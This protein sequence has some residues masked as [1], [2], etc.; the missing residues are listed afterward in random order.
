M[1]HQNTDQDKYLN[2]A[3]NCQTCNTMSKRS[4]AWCF[5]YWGV[6]GDHKKGIQGVLPPKET[7]DI[8]CR[9]ILVGLETSNAGWLHHQGFVM[10][11]NAST[12]NA[13]KKVLPIGC[14]LEACKGTAL[15]NIKY[16]SK[17][18]NIVAENGKRPEQ[19]KRN[20]METV[21][22]IIKT[23]GRMAD[24]T[25]NVRS[26]QAMK[27][28][29]LILKYHEPK[30]FTKPFVGWFWGPT[31]CSKTHSAYELLGENGT[32][33][34]SGPMKW[35]EGYD[36]EQNVIIDD[37]R[38]HYCDFVTLLSL[39][40]R[41][42]FRVENK[43]GSRQLQA[44]NIIVTSCYPP[45]KCFR[46]SREDVK[47]LL[48][49]IDTI[50]F[51]NVVYEGNLGCINYDSSVAH[52]AESRAEIPPGFEIPIDT[53]SENICVDTPADTEVS[54]SLTIAP[55]CI[56]FIKNV[57]TGPYVPVTQK[58]GRGN[59]MLSHSTTV[60]ETENED[61]SDLLKEL[62]CIF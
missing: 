26:Y 50:K 55:E 9:Y 52:S 42:P 1:I 27:A 45:D 38:E 49:R 8:P 3:E 57:P 2:R 43:G 47:Q 23:T 37:F 33:K 34:S 29:E 36:G 20:D 58:C 7:Y 61:L 11:A 31:G 18:G 25:E 46:T 4:R 12:A 59:T 13:V 24:V 19:G 14:H 41:Y 21:F 5:T 15:Q 60:K 30:R 10:F 44:R 53:S 51:Y 56:P 6:G 32:W 22:K 16:C 62:G 28:G 40:D 54:V 39:L 35:W 17:D 48:R